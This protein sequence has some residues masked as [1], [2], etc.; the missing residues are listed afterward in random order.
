M[1]SDSSESESNED[2]NANPTALLSQLRNIFFLPLFGET[3]EDD[4]QSMSEVAKQRHLVSFFTN[5]VAF[6]ASFDEVLPFI[7]ISNV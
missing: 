1:E 4:E 2:E 3:P 7:Y 5:A 6:A